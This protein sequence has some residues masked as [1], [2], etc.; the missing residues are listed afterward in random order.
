MGGREQRRRRL[1]RAACPVPRGAGPLARDL[2][3]LATT[4]ILL[5]GN[6]LT[7]ELPLGWSSGTLT[8]LDLSYNLITG[9]GLC[10]AVG[11]HALLRDGRQRACMRSGRA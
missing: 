5:G 11:Y 4:R 3:G 6:R 7:G 9:A 2:V 1:G 10:C 8:H